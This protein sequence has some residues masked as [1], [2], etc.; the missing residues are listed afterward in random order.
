MFREF[1]RF[2]LAL[3][4]R[5]PLL[6]IAAL[7]FGVMA[8]AASSS[9]A[10]Q[11]GGAIGNIHRNAP[12]VIIQFLTI[13][14][15]LALFIVTAFLP[16]SLLRDH[17]LNT[18]E[19]F[20][21]KPMRKADYL[22]GRL[23]GGLAATV[24]IYVVIILAMLLGTAMPW[25][26][27]ARLGPTSLAPYLWALTVMVLPNIVFT[28]AL[29]SVLA[30]TMRSLLGVY[31]GIAGFIVLWSVAS[32]LSADIDNQWLAALIDPFG[33]NALSQETRYWSA[34]EL[35]SKLPTLD[36]Y[37]LGNRLLWLAAS[38]V[39]IL[40]SYVLFKPMRAG[41]GRGWRKKAAAA[42]PTISSTAFTHQRVEP[43]F[44]AATR[45]Q[46]WRA[47]WWFDTVGVL[48]GVPF[49]AMLVF[50]L[51]NLLASTSLG[52]VMYGT[53]VYPVTH[54]MTGA[55]GD[56]F[57]FLLVLI[58]T[59]YAGELIWK[60]RQARLGDVIDALPVPNWLPLSAKAVALITVV[61]SYL[62]A[63]VLAA[64]GFQ[65]Y[66]G[67]TNI[68]FGLYASEVLLES[69]PFVLMGLLALALQVFFQNKFLG[70]LA[71]I[72][73]IV[74]RVSLQ[75][76]DYEHQ[77][78]TFGLATLLTY[79]DMNGY[80]HFLT[81][82]LSFRAYWLLFC[83]ALLILAAALWVRGIVP[84][85]P[86]R[87]QSAG[88]QLRGPLGAGLAV[89]VLAWLGVGGW[90]FW[91]TNI[92]NDYLT[93]NDELD[94]QAEYERRY[95][96]YK[97]LVQPRLTA[98]SV[99]LDLYPTE[100][101]AVAR[102]RYELVNRSAEPITDLHLALVD[103]DITLKSLSLP[104]SA[105]Q[106]HDVDFGYR[107][108]KLPQPLQPGA[109]TT[110]DFE[111]EYAKR[112]FA[113]RNNESLVVDNGSFINNAQ[114]LPQFGY[115]EDYLITDRNERRK[116]NL[117]ERPR[118]PKLEDEAARANTYIGDDGDW[119]RFETTVS[120]VPDQ[121]A[122]APG[123]LQKEWTDN[124]RRYFHYK[125]DVP[126]LPFFSWLSARWDVKRDSWNGIPI[127]IYYDRK[128][129]YNVDRMIT[130]VKDS[131]S[132]FSSQFSPYQHKQVRIL[133][134][135]RYASFAQSFANT[136]PYSESIGFI[137]DLRDQDS[138]DYVYYVTAHEIAHQWWAH[139]VIGANVQGATVLSES[140]SQ[141][142]ALMVMEKAYG[143]QQMRQFLKNELDGYLS[144]RGGELLE[145]LPLYRVEN[146]QYIHYEKG[147]L[148][149]YRLREEI[150]ED[151]LNRALSKFLHDKG[152]QQAPFTTSAELLSYIRAETPVDRQQL[153]TDLFEKISFYDNRMLAAS[154]TK[155][156][157]GKYEVTLEFSADKRYADGVGNETEGQLDDWI[158]VAVFA[159]KPGAEERD[160]TVL[161]QERRHIT[162]KQHKLTVTVD[163]EPYEAGF[164]PYNKLIDRVSDDNRKRV[165]LE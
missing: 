58:V 66:K 152:Y 121:I 102:G 134:F 118:M 159:R 26:D 2:E 55:I 97:N 45:W 101:R 164:D 64:V 13:F 43:Q 98:I 69:L 92:V 37:L 112:G 103:T 125:M 79:S 104:D 28:G 30:V 95:A 53:T 93:D 50:G 49:L 24:S 137:A 73:V 20:F 157:D 51:L 141:Y 99:D 109:T 12:T 81:G 70:Y 119:I 149:F 142:S 8:F 117:P 36:R 114:L 5:Q 83:V 129:P 133:E 146:Q 1:F 9:D 78:Y 165:T 59:F 131:L 71:I 22:G 151:A 153:V 6:W 160:E 126:M 138:V 145:E 162:D 148:V 135:P 150:G 130:A 48:K 127:E 128:H 132:Y 34:A 38:A 57:S 15:V 65:L 111:L 21:S 144:A 147:S 10:V 47:Q 19:L 18:A 68:E 158:D 61:F 140:L 44:S 11:L 116:R 63:G 105:L 161:Y 89:V 82:H 124:G 163:S 33:G 87:L 106:Q 77:L 4:I 108:Y 91:N 122:L 107:I 31:I 17:E 74:A 136:I 46:Q 23:L 154:A 120:T 84:S 35:N 123:Y 14:T 110:L 155:R 54:M 143:R 3:Q 80:G 75:S 67:F 100:R 60:E 42:E 62:G 156:D 27:P 86:A 85:F 113:T 29:L 16:G 39:L 88:K 90:I 41:T 115:N 76:L 139:Q 96:Q 7:I 94:W 40:L 32:V 25:L 72:V 52:G 56:S